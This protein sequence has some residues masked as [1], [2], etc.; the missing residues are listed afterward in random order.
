VNGG[1]AT[2]DRD[3]GTIVRA[4]LRHLAPAPDNPDTE[5]AE[6]LTAGPKGRKKILE[7]WLATN[8]T[9]QNNSQAAAT[10]MNILL[11][12]DYA[13]V[14]YLEKNPGSVAWI[15]IWIAR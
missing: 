7:G 9:A 8:T 15:A 2:P 3:V 12:A 6:W 11:R 14:R 10:A 1:K 5:F 4:F 13:E